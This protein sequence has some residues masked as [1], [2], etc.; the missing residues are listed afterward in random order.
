ML[1]RRRISLCI[2]RMWLTACTTSP[3]PGSPL[4]RIIVSAFSD[5]AQS[6]AQIL[7]S[8]E[9]RARR[10]WSCR[11]GRCCLR[12]REPRSRRYNR[13]QWPAVSGLRRC[14]RCGTWPS[15]GMVTASWMPRIIL[16]SLMR[17][18]PPAARISAGM[19]SRAITAQAPAASAIRACS[20]VVTSIITPP[21]SIWANWRFSSCLLVS[22][23]VFSF[24]VDVFSAAKERLFV[25]NRKRGS[26]YGKRKLI[27]W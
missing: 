4:V 18:T 12:V 11:Y 14:G 20:G 9:R 10:T 23:F 26:R 2:S 3:V 7:G 15:T 25:E 21:F 17:E 13:S 22:I 5:A 24:M 8:A 16:G 1:T 27:F 6:L 19:R